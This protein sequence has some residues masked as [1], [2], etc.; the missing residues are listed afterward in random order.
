MAIHH[1]RVALVTGSSRGIGQAIAEQLCKDGYAVVINYANSKS[2]AEETVSRLTEEGGQAI[3]AKASVAQPAGRTRLVDAAYEE[4]GRLDLLVNNAGITSQGRSD[5]LD[6][7]EESWDVVLDTNLKGPFFLSKDAANRMVAQINTGEIA[8][9]QIINISSISAFAASTNRADYCIAKAGMTMMTSLFASRLA[10]EN[11]NVYEI[12]PGVIA[13]S[14]TD[15]VKAIYDERIADG[16]TPIRR[17]GQPSDVAAA[18][19][20]IAGGQFPF[21]TGEVFHVDG[22]FHIRRL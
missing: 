19:S 20:A 6:A 8:G 10:D 18:V 16:L 17:W 5:L 13:T 14:M 9:A 7:T 3:A 22:G 1:Q 11:I 4:W 15:G 2:A 12:A 21:S